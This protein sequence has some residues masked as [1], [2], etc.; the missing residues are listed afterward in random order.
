MESENKAKLKWYAVQTF[1]H[2][3]NEISKLLTEQ[4]IANFIPMRYAEKG[5][6]DGHKKRILVPAVH[7]LVFMQADIQKA[8]MKDFQARCTIPAR[9]IRKQDT[10]DYYVIPDSEMTEFRAICDPNYTGTL[11]VTSE[12]A[13]AKVGQ[14]VIVTHGTFKGLRGKLVRYKNRYYVVKVLTTAGVM[15]HIPKWYCEKA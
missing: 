5:D 6:S 9:I 8:D 15:L 10:D 13:E 2:K 11:Y 1:N 7:N 3:E 14:E 12:F 4:G